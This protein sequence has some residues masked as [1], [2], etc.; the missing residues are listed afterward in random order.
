VL[1]WL[2]NDSRAASLSIVWLPMLSSDNAAA[3]CSSATLFH[4]RRV[5]QFW[6]PARLT[7]VAWSREF[8]AA[9]V[10]VLLD[11]LAGDDR[12]RPYLEQ[13][14]ADPTSRPSW[15]VA[16]FYRRGMRW[17]DHVPRPEGW[18][19]QVGFWGV[20]EVADS[21]S[22]AR[23]ITG[24]FWTDRRPGQT[25]DSDWIEEYASGMNRVLAPPKK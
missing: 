12:M 17:R 3:A 9:L 1:H 20:E 23:L 13:W 16:Y 11:S 21:T 8:Q 25:I 2:E 4:D 14:V 5:A 7:G 18:T 24:E 6:D 10:P 22:A 19:K 15:D